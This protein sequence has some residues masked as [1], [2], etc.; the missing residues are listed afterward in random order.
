MPLSPADT[1]RLYADAFQRNSRA[2]LGDTSHALVEIRA[3][4]EVAQAEN[5]VLADELKAMEAKLG[6]KA[7]ELTQMTA[8]YEATEE[9]KAETEAEAVLSRTPDDIS[10]D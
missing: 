8:K 10:S 9:G 7:I 6:A 5:S 2:L 1:N 4:L 3:R